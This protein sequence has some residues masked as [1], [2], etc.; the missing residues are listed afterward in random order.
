M[1]LNISQTQAETTEGCFGSDKATN[2]TL[3]IRLDASPSETASIQKQKLDD[4]YLT[5]FTVEYAKDIERMIW[6]SD[7]LNKDGSYIFRSLSLLQRVER[8]VTEACKGLKNTID[9]DE[10]FG[11]SKSIDL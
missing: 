1:K 3:I 6:I 2:Y 8:E 11:G 4:K 7:I 5:K 10:N 9:A